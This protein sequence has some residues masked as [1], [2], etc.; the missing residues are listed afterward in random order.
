M[1]TTW[2]YH[3]FN[4]YAAF[5]EFTDVVYGYEYEVTVTDEVTS[6]TH[7]GAVRL[8]C[9]TIAN[10]V[11]FSEL[12][13]EIVQQWTEASINSVEIIKNLTET[14]IAKNAET[15]TDLP[16]PWEPVVPAESAAPVA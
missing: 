15:R 1:K 13:Q 6:A 11:P 10:Y 7:Y 9:D 14:V 2:K 4:V 12:T 5:G 8:N 3:K 16:A